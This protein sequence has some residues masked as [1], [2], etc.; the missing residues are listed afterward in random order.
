MD[1]FHLLIPFSNCEYIKFYLEHQ[2]PPMTGS[3]DDIENP[4]TSLVNGLSEETKLEEE[5]V[6]IVNDGVDDKSIEQ[7]EEKASSNTDTHEPLD[8]GEVCSHSH[9]YAHSHPHTPTHP[10][11]HTHA[12]LYICSGYCLLPLPA[13]FLRDKSK[14]SLLGLEMFTLLEL[15]L[16]RRIE[17]ELRMCMKN[18]HSFY[19]K[20]M[21]R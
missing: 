8:E 7:N 11:T 16:S 3:D 21:V 19:T 1:V 9:T 14:Y 13:K 6:G 10:H 12:C 20:P 18:Y 5:C 15:A 2:S 17:L 4:K